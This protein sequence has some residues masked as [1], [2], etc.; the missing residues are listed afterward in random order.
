M[1][2]STCFISISFCMNHTYSISRCSSCGETWP[3][4]AL[5]SRTFEPKAQISGL[6]TMSCFLLNV[7]F[8]SKWNT[9]RLLYAFDEIDWA[10]ITSIIRFSRQ[11]LSI[12]V[13]RKDCRSAVIFD[14]FRPTGATSAHV[15]YRLG[16]S[17][18]LTNFMMKP[19]T[20][21]VVF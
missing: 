20:A 4:G 8:V 11:F 21:G 2:V 10:Q 7:T 6:I 12:N 5:N 14:A 15:I 13:H 17:D 16:F 3:G 19:L 9:G 1:E 18:V